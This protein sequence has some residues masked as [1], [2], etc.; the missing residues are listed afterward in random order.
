MAGAPVV[1]M[2]PAAVPDVGVVMIVRVARTHFQ[3]MIA[4][5]VIA[6][7]ITVIPAPIATEPVAVPPMMVV[8]IGM[9]VLFVLL[10]FRFGG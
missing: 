2:A 9:L 6:V 1:L 4:V 8:V 3:A 5:I 7:A 10:V